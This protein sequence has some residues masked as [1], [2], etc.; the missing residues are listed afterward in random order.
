M[1]DDVTLESINSIGNNQEK[2]RALKELADKVIGVKNKKKP[3]VKSV[4]KLVTFVVKR[5][6]E[7][8]TATSKPTL[9]YLAEQIAEIEEDYNS[10]LAAIVKE[11]VDAIRPKYTY[12]PAPLVKLVRVL[13]E[14]HQAEEE[15][16]DA[17]RAMASVDTEDQYFASVM[18]IAERCEWRISAAQFFLQDEDNAAATTHIQ[19]SRKL[20]R[21]VPL[22]HPDRLKLDLQQ[23][24]CYSRI[25]DSERKFLAAAV[26]YMELSQINSPLVQDRDLLQSLENAVT[27]A[28]LA[29]AG[30]NRTRVLAMLYR[31]ERARTLKN[32]RV[33]ERMH[34]NMLLPKKKNKTHLQ[35]L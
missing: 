13:V 17:G 20:L 30:G 22:A 26:N 35:Q 15:W 21:E 25:L 4:N 19:K 34:K 27:C 33:L 29:P 14:L 12:F 31:D 5:I 28:I 10:E 7:N 32:F 2:V 23:K 3:D 6:G 1:C 18:T 11:G 9:M 16:R 8:D 24:T